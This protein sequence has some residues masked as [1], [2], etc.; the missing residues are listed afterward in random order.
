MGRFSRTWRLS[1]GLCGTLSVLAAF[2]AL[3]GTSDAEAVTRVFIN[4]V[5]TPVYFSDGDSFRIK[6]GRFAG[7]STR[8]AGFN[9]LES[10][11]P[12]QYWGGWHPYELWVVAK[13]ATKNARKGVW[14]CDTDESVDGYGR[15]LL[16]CQ[17]LAVDQIRKG[18]AHAMNID[19]TPAR[20]VYIRAQAEAIRERRGMWAHGVPSFVLTSVHSA[21]EDPSRDTHY[22]RMV[23][24]RD[25]HSERMAHNDV[26]AE[27]D[28]V[29]TEEVYVDPAVVK[30]AARALREAHPEWVK[31]Y[32]NILVEEIVDRFA[33]L[34]ELPE[35]VE[36]G[37]R[38]G[39]VNWLSAK[40]AAGELGTPQARQGACMV[41]V[42][43]TRWYGRNRAS[44]L[45]GR[46]QY[47]GGHQ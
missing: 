6:G 5:S 34:G 9:T 8:L 23:S 35:W 21:S 25:G 15:M 3:P 45:H 28:A 43:F 32:A 24:T 7:K 19:D 29:C 2:A 27:C 42:N 44:C 20:P 17:D 38:S 47:Q 30:A 18:Y 14:H 36:A 39:L 4:G 16:D 1:L 31:D 26:Y 13:K 22:N 46:G 37:A 11:G 41:Y 33:R 12:A 10:F 40:K